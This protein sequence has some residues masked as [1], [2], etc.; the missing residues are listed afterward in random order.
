MAKFQ[1]YDFT[2]PITFDKGQARIFLLFPCSALALREFMMNECS[3]NSADGDA[4]EGKCMTCSEMGEKYGCP[5]AVIALRKWEPSAKDIAVLAHECF[6]AAE[7]ILNQAGLEAPLNSPGEPWKAWEDM[8]YLLEWIMRR[9][10]ARLEDA[11][12]ELAV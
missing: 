12:P 6:H 7:W 4:W 2:V 10:I 9:A 1:V 5:T 3:V 11:K 8:A